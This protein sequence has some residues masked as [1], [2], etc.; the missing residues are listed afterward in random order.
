M[1]RELAKSK[2]LLLAG[3]CFFLGWC[4]P[5]VSQAQEKV[6]VLVSTGDLGSLEDSFKNIETQAIRT[7]ERL[8]FRVIIVG[9]VSQPG[10]PLSSESF[11]QTLSQLKDVKDLRVDFIGHGSLQPVPSSMKYDGPEIKVSNARRE[12]GNEFLDPKR[13]GKLVWLAAN[14]SSLDGSK[15]THYA[16]QAKLYGFYREML[17]LSHRRVAEALD[18]FRAQNP[19]AVTTVNLLNCFSGA[20]AQ[21]LRMTPNT[22]VYANSPHNEVAIDLGERTPSSDTATSGDFIQ[23]TNGLGLYYS[24][25][26]SSVKG[27]P[28]FNALRQQANQKMRSLQLDPGS[29]L[30]SWYFT[31]RSPVFE[32][33]IGWCEAG[34]PGKLSTAR[35]KVLDKHKLTFFIVSN[36]VK[37]SK[38][39]FEYASHL[40]SLSDP[41]ITQVDTLK[42]A[43]QKCRQSPE[44]V[45]TGSKSN[46]PQASPASVRK[47]LQRLF[48]KYETVLNDTTQTETIFANVKLSLERGKRNLRESQLP[49]H[50]WGAIKDLM[51]GVENGHITS[52]DIVSSLK[53]AVHQMKSDCARGIPNK[54]SCV[55]H[56]GLQQEMSAIFSSR[57]PEPKPKLQCSRDKIE[58]DCVLTLLEPKVPLTGT[59]IYLAGAIW[60]PPP[61]VQSIEER[62]A[63]QPWLAFLKIKSNVEQDEQCFR[64]FEQFAPDAEWDNIDRIHQ[65]G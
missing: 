57:E 54:S 23:S 16:N 62:C 36:E 40:P 5:V 27:N 60:S 34:Q 31:G 17:P 47:V 19:D 39:K 6:A 48:S 8:G 45:S 22:V 13:P 59:A 12:S 33:I 32:S 4:D 28:S 30:I 18:S 65:L 58:V 9:G 52:K 64:D 42:Q 37:S 46:E 35:A 56:F 41:Q 26:E 25:L 20:M 53:K 11:K 38:A 1:T 10:Q 7:Y 50:R 43:D 14:N 44:E 24:A 55:D 2:F 3:A 21:E 29:D 15:N 63:S 51:D 49:E 61:Q